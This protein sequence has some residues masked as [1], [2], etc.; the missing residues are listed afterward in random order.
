MTSPACIFGAVLALGSKE[1]EKQFGSSTQSVLFWS[2]AIEL[3]NTCRLAAL[4][5]ETGLIPQSFTLFSSVNYEEVVAKKDPFQGRY[6]LDANYVQSLFVLWR[7]TKNEQYR[8]YAWE[9][10]LAI[11]K[12]CSVM[13]ENGKDDEGGGY[14]DIEDV[15]VVPTHYLI[16]Y[17]SPQFISATLKYLY[18]IFEEDD[19][20]PLDKWIFTDA[21]QALPICGQHERYPKFACS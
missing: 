18:L 6:F 4:S 9:Y 2:L 21:G 10:A 8:K 5:T 15:N 17:Q 19:V 16:D 12:H 11:Q 3:M 20:L 13:N 14:S 7:Y 1:L